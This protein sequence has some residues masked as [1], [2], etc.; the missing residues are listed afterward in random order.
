MINVYYIVLKLIKKIYIER[1]KPNMVKMF[2][3]NL[4][5]G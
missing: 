5:G 4:G 3:L 1:K 2:I